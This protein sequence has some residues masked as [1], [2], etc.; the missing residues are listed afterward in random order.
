MSNSSELTFNPTPGQQQH[1]AAEAKRYA[2]QQLSCAAVTAISAYTSSSFV[3]GCEDGQLWLTGR[4][5]SC[6]LLQ[7]DVHCKP[8]INFMTRSRP[9]ITACRVHDDLLLT[10]D[11]TG[12][13]SLY[14]LS[15]DCTITHSK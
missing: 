2:H 9:H 11:S 8:N 12:R 4:L 13:V 3:L 14:S 6:Q 7:N 5:G 10:G 1:A 15:A